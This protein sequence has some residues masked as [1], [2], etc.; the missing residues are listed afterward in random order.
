[1][2]RKFSVTLLNHQHIL[3][4]RGPRLGLKRLPDAVREALSKTLP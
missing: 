3:L 2:T 4:I 1:M